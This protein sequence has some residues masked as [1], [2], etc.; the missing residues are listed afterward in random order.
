MSLEVRAVVAELWRYFCSVVSLEEK[1]AS[2]FLKKLLFDRENQTIV[3]SFVPDSLFLRQVRFEQCQAVRRLYYEPLSPSFFKPV[4]DTWFQ[5]LTLLT[6]RKL[7]T[8]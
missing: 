2:V 4:T 8:Q 5:L 1:G 6:Q 7:M 3:L